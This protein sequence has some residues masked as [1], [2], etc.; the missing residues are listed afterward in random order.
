M[1]VE[2]GHFALCLTLMAALL[3]ASAPIV[4]L[5]SEN[6]ALFRLSDSASHVQL[7]ENAARD[8]LA[9]FDTGPKRSQVLRSAA[10]LGL[11]IN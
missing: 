11:A 1:I 5:R 3:Q 9:A 2:F 6:A 8:A 10:E 7:A 4:G